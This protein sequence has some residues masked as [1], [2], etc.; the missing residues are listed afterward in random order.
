[1]DPTA[2]FLLFIV[3]LIAVL[4]AF[5]TL[6]V[7]V[8]RRLNGK[9]P[10]RRVGRIEAVVIGGIVLGIIMMF[11]QI[12]LSLFEPGFVVLL[13]ST[14]AFV[15]WSHITPRNDGVAARGAGADVAEH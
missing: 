11:Q 9:W 12:T 1:M 6:I 14:L 3:V 13:F 4:A 10:R 8:A 2:Q 7:V 5:I 15:L